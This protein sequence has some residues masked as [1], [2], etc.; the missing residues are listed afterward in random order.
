MKISTDGQQVVYEI[1]HGA[2]NYATSFPDN[3]NA[4]NVIDRTFADYAQVMWTHLKTTG[5]PHALK[6]T[7]HIKQRLDALH[8]PFVDVVHKTQQFVVRHSS[9]TLTQNIE[10]LY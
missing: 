1:T 2:F 9:Q 7:K 8:V 10:V 5:N 4:T 3:P 6:L